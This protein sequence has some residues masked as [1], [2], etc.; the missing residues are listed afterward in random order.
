[1][2]EPIQ[3][4]KGMRFFL[5]QNRIYKGNTTLPM[6]MGYFLERLMD[7]SE[8]KIKKWRLRDVLS[9]YILLYIL[10]YSAIITISFVC[11]KL[12]LH[13]NKIEENVL[14]KF[15]SYASLLLPIWFLIKRYPILKMRD[16][17][18]FNRKGLLPFI[19]GIVSCGIFSIIGFLN[20][21]SGIAT[22]MVPLLN[23]KGGYR[24]FFLINL[25]FFIPVIEELYFRGLVFTILKNRFDS[26]WGIIITTVLFILG[27][28]GSW[29][30]AG[31]S[32]IIYTLVYE[33]TNCL[34]FA[35]LTH[36]IYN[37]MA[38]VSA[39]IIFYFF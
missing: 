19:I 24:I 29:F 21:P 18:F 38:I 5:S 6:Q 17:I 27:H 10:G 8:D 20:V 2:F 13:L 26:F 25:L 33:K 28:P 37:G 22:P 12:D 7:I 9:S 11:K 16:L 35:I 34:L 39:L 14:L 3:V 32:S 36:S 30:N 1:M 4:E 31:I 23:S 15:V